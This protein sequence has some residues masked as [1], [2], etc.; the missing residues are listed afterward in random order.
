LTVDDD[1]WC[2]GPY[3]L[4][5]DHMPPNLMPPLDS[6]LLALVG[7]YRSWSPWFP[8]FRI[9]ARRG[10]LVLIAPGGVEAP[11]DDE[12]LV[13]LAP[14]LF[15]IGADPW[16]PERLVVGPVVDGHAVTVE[17]DGCVYSRHFTP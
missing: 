2:W 16:L 7:H 11:G 8:G 17:R 5:P 13:E 4:A 9:V 10:G 1:C 6:R 14:G 3:V 12:H 15:R